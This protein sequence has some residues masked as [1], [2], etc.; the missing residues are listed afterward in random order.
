MPL[1]VM[2]MFW[3]DLST[4]F[5]TKRPRRMKAGRPLLHASSFLLSA[6]P[7]LGLGFAYAVQTGS[8]EEV[9]PIDQ[10]STVPVSPEAAANEVSF[11]RIT[12]PSEGQAELITIQIAPPG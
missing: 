11:K 8:M 7:V 5:R 3:P 10:V 4:R 2:A 6:A 1:H 12:P 9:E